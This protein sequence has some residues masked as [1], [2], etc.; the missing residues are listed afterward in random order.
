MMRTVLAL[1]LL[2]QGSPLEE[3]RKADF[4]QK[5]GRPDDGWK[6]RILL[7]GEIVRSGKPEPIRAA[8]ADPNRDVRASAATAL[9]ILGDKDSVA[10]IE[11]L[12]RS[13]SD[14][15][16]RGMAVQA[17]GWLK[18]GAA[19]IQAAKS[20][21]SRDVQF[22]AAAAEGRLKDPTDYAAKV[23]EAYR[24]ALKPEELASAEVGKPSPD[25]AAIDSDGKP[26]KLS[27]ILKK[28]VVVLTFQLADW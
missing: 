27:D 25:F 3:Y 8:L 13:D 17:L 14:P 12:A 26:F 18:A 19:T 22:L 16:V 6:R 15:L 1:A 21:E 4:G 24:A 20:D 23:L 10:K 7:E 28:R 5:K 2:L 9:G 11:A